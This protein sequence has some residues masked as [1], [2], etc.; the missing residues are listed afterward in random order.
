MQGLTRGFKN[1][2]L[3]PPNN[4]GECDPTPRTTPRIE[5]G[6]CSPRATSR[7]ANRPRE[8]RGG[9]DIV[10]LTGGPKA[11]L[12]LDFDE[13]LKILYLRFNSRSHFSDGPGKCGFQLATGCG[14]L[15]PFRLTLASYPT[16]NK[17][18]STSKDCKAEAKRS[19]HHP[20]R[21]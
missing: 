13:N 1:R 17:E 9:A 16:D 21:H 12:I 15:N 8:Q 4:G 10:D 5:I 20:Q 2:R 11:P 14:K 3:T 7:S 19:G 6:C 18:S